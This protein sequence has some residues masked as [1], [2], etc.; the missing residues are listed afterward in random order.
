[1][2]GNLYKSSGINAGSEPVLGTGN[3]VW[4]LQ[5]PLA[6]QFI[7][8]PNQTPLSR[9]V[10][11][12]EAYNVGGWDSTKIYTR[13]DNVLFSD[14]LYQSR[15]N[16]NQGN[17][18]TTDVNN[19]GFWSPLSANLRPFLGTATF[20]P[21]YVQLDINNSTDITILQSAA[22]GFNR[23]KFGQTLSN[24]GTIPAG[25]HVA[26]LTFVSPQTVVNTLGMQNGT[27]GNNNQRFRNLI[28]LTNNV[29][30][31]TSTI[32]TAI[33]NQIVAGSASTTS[34]GIAA[35]SGIWRINAT[36]NPDNFSSVIFTDPDLTGST[37]LTSTYLDG[38]DGNGALG[39]ALT[40]M[41]TIETSFVATVGQRF[42]AGE[43]ALY[44]SVVYICISSYVTTSAFT[45]SPLLDGVH[46]LR[47]S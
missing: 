17:S 4:L 6:N 24:G 46:W 42:I 32:A 15:D 47:L 1:M 28:T 20:T 25:S 16:S 44:E 27:A 29:A 37:A 35:V 13:R 2:G 8:D 30:P 33:A 41:P 19:T 18:P 45:D 12:G 26:D 40:N 38:S 22:L 36:V 14:Q 7:L 10:I 39:W 43:M 23:D 31:A 21:G 34:S 11:N 3:T 9:I 5:N